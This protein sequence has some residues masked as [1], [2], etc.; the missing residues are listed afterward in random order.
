[1]SGPKVF[2]VV[3]REEIIAICQGHLARVDAAVAEWMRAAQQRG[4]ASPADIEAV[5][6]RQQALHRLFAQDRFTD[7]QKQ[8]PAEI[9][10]LESDAQAR[11]ERAAAAEVEARQA[12][13]RAGRTA[14]MLL[15]ELDRAGRAVPDELRQTLTSAGPNSDT[16]ASAVER[17]FRLLSDT[18]SAPSV[19]EKQRALAEQL[20][21]GEARV[22]LAQWVAEQPSGPDERSTLQID[23]HLAALAVL[24]VDASPFERR[25]VEIA[26]AEPSSHRTLLA[27]S[28][29]LDLAAALKAG[30][31][32][33]AAF[34][35][36]RERKIE[37][38]RMRTPQAQALATGIDQ[39][40][41][42]HD[43]VASP[44]LLK[45]ADA[46]IADQ[47]RTM[48]AAARRRTILQ[49]LSSLGY[50]VT[51]GMATAWVENGRV[52]LRKAASPDYGVELGGGLQ[53]DRLQVRAV[54]FGTTGALRD[55]R[56]DRDMEA[57]WCSEFE[58]LQTLVGNDGGA[59]DVE[60]AVPVGVADFKTIEVADFKI[61]GGFEESPGEEFEH[62]AART[63]NR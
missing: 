3:T 24:N 57:I 53:S 54:A 45:Q 62:P 14:Q 43:A 47:V 28:L 32:R 1:M 63:L 51:E 21:R 16:L 48:A 31:E 8:A 17:A 33:E 6:A 38:S 41:H 11:R 46:L 35:K 20:G 22:M 27:D 26:R 37:L 61:I 42:G 34:A 2:R 39:A 29:I 4:A 12:G 10:F 15:R 49:G 30:R 58:R 13:R 56:R 44:T 52:V 59:L 9:S 7:V 23:Q 18:P 19:S 40:L 25:A 5:R 60:K 36:L 55:A 50:E